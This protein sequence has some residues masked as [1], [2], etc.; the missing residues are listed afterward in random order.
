MTSWGPD[1]PTH[2]HIDPKMTS[3][4]PKV[5]GGSTYEGCY[6]AWAF[7]SSAATLRVRLGSTWMPG[8]MVVETV[9]FL[10]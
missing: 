7:S 5:P 10:M 4:R 1:R 8:P 2:P 3:T 9:T 6:Q